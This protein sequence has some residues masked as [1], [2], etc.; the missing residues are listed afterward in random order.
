MKTKR[1]VF[2][3]L[4]LSLLS[5]NYVT[6]MIVPPTA[7]PLPTSTSTP[8]RFPLPNAYPACTGIYPASM[9]GFAARHDFA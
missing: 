9:F 7:T 6:Q 2:G 8:H 1:I 5:C 3:F 4:V